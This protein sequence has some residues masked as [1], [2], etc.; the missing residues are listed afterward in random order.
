VRFGRN[1]WI[2][3]FHRNGLG[4]IGG[5][6]TWS[7]R[8]TDYIPLA[9]LASRVWRSK[10]YCLHSIIT[11]RTPEI[12]GW[13]T[14][15][16]THAVLA[17]VWTEHDTVRVTV[18]SLNVCRLLSVGYKNLIIQGTNIRLTCIFFVPV[19]HREQYYIM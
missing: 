13:T 6:F 18:V 2:A 10:G 1:I 16:V 14:A 15:A 4:E 17:N 8:S 9:S 12:G 3:S 11:N 7:P 19:P 5:P